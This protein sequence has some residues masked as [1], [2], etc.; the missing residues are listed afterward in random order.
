MLIGPIISTIFHIALVIVLAVLITDKYQQEPTEIEVKMEEVEEVKIEEPP[1]IE[2]PI[3]EVEQTEDVTNPVLTTVA[4]ENVD[5]NDVALEDV[6]D[7]APSTE[8]DS[9]IE[10]VSDVVV[11]PS[12]FASPSV[13]GGRSA[14]GRASAVSQFGGSQ[15]GQQALLK[16]LWWLAKVQ[17]PDG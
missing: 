16:A 5:T 8:D 15:V 7:E 17:N 12:A 1:P 14:A 11:S 6:S 4:I 13:F 3:P 10:A 9:T 2:E